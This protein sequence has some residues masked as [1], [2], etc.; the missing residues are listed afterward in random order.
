MH[1]SIMFGNCTQGDLALGAST[2]LPSFDS[3]HPGKYF[4][5]WVSR[6]QYV[7]SVRRLHGALAPFL[8]LVM[9]LPLT[10]MC[11]YDDPV[12][13]IKRS[14]FAPAHLAA[15]SLYKMA[16]MPRDCRQH[17][18]LSQSVAPQTLNQ[19][20]LAKSYRAH[21]NLISLLTTWLCK[22]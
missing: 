1:R 12:K 22:P 15:P 11:M 5:S 8:S 13:L 3:R 18:W 9:A 10:L 16:T 21:S 2:N 19:N 6:V 4:R 17:Y 20:W 14:V 7:Q